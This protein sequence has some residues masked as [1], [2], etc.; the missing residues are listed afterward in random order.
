MTATF[1]PTQKS[2]LLGFSF[3]AMTT[4]LQAALT[5]SLHPDGAGGTVVRVF[6][7]GTTTTAG[8]QLTTTTLSE[9]WLNLTGNPFDDTI[10]LDNADYYFASPIQIASGVNMIGIQIDND[11]TDPVG[12][13]GADDFR[14]YIDNAM[15]PNTPYSADGVTT[16]QTFLRNDALK[17][18]SYYDDSD[19][20]SLF[21]NGF[22]L[23]ISDQAIVPEPSTSLILLSG[24]TALSLRRSRR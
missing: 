20:G 8:S 18:G 1:I 9:Q 11:P 2:I 7:S 13:D 14:V 10:D 24:L 16:L 12:G 19:G 15:L 22:T 21:L 5:V 23:Q 17:V 6:G 4:G 3:L